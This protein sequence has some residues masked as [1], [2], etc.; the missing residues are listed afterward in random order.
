MRN[1]VEQT[2]IHG[3]GHLSLYNILIIPFY[4]SKSNKTFA[5]KIHQTGKPATTI[6]LLL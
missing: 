6:V 3:P 4:V 5:I 1:K 2:I